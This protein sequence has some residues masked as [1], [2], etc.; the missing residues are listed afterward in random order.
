MNKRR[1]LALVKF[2]EALPRKHWERFDMAMYV[3]QGPGFDGKDLRTGCDTTACAFGWATQVP[4]LKRLGLRLS[5]GT[6]PRF[7]N[8][9]GQNAAEKLFSLTGIEAS[10]L[11]DD[12]SDTIKTPRQWAKLARGFIENG[13]PEGW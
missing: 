7:G 6:I 13:L 4:S 2:M 8:N 11:F 12:L 1:L 9:T 10:Y 3:S 5:H